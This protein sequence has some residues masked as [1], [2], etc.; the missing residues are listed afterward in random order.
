M[1]MKYLKVLAS[2]K[3]LGF[4]EVLS[5][6]DLPVKRSPKLAIT[7]W[8]FHAIDTWPVRFFP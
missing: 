2:K 8:S 7:Q 3:Q 4:A 6:R 1:R 5:E